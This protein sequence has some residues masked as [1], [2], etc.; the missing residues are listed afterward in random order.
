MYWMV[1]ML[2]GEF[3]RLCASNPWRWIDVASGY[4][5]LATANV[6][7]A[8][9]TT[10][11]S[12][13]G[14]LGNFVPANEDPLV[15]SL[16]SAATICVWISL[17]GYIVQWWCGMAI[18]FGSAVQLLHTMFWPLIVAPMGIVGMAQVLYT[19]GD[20]GQDGMCTLSDAYTTVYWMILGEPVLSEE[21]EKGLSNGMIAL[22]VSFTLLWI[23]WIV[24]VIVMSVTEAHQLDRRQIA[25]RWYW[26]PKVAL[27]VLSGGR[28][29]KKKEKMISKLSCTQRYCIEME[30]IWQILVSALQGEENQSKHDDTYWYSCFN[31][32]SVI[33]LTRL[34]A[35]VVLPLWFV[36]GVATLGLLWPPQLRRWLFSTSIINNRKEKQQ[37]L[38]EKL[39]ASK[40]SRLKGDLLSFKSM[41]TEQN[42][43]TQNDLQEIKELLYLAMGKQ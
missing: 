12:L 38:E 15:S 35:L 30:R 37:A 13:V 27:T 5:A 31:R 19:I 1:A 2:A 20:C 11:E 34:L 29:G 7:A 39:T 22:M 9:A 36:S 40:V 26:E 43:M 14:T 24:S 21:S 25:L 18:F 10:L 8:D 32:P 23:W 3:Y 42:Q 16:G 33:Y 6:I 4:L 28:T 41:T 17:V